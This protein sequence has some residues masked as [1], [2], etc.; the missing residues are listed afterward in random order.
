MMLFF[1]NL[2]TED[3]LKFLS[4]RSERLEAQSAIGPSGRAG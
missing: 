1:R 4:E 2:T 3:C